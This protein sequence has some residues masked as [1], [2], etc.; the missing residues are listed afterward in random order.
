MKSNVNKIILLCLV[1]FTLMIIIGY[2]LWAILIPIQDFDLIDSKEQLRTRKEL[3]LNYTLGE[4]LLHIG[5]ISSL[6]LLILNQVM[7]IKNKFVK[8]LLYLKIGYNFRF[9]K[10]FFQSS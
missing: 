5:F 1:L 9:F 6:I 7:A 4:N 8:Q 2:F 10:F 3:V